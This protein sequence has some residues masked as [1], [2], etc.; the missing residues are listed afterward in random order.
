M[1]STSLHGF[2]KMLGFEIF[3]SF[4][5]RDRAGDFENPNKSLRKLWERKVLLFDRRDDSKVA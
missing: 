4:K 5:I 3:G 2:G 1:G